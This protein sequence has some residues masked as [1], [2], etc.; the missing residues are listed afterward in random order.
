MD[1]FFWIMT[2]DN[3]PKILEI[4]RKYNPKK[5]KLQ[6]SANIKTVA[7]ELFFNSPKTNIQSFNTVIFE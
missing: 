6:Y 4:Y 1:K 2:Y 7:T 5:Y 3:E